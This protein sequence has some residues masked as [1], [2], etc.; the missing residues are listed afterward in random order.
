MEDDQ[1][2]EFDSPVDKKKNKYET[3]NDELYFIL[4]NE[5]KI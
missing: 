5:E 3:V 4:T 2:D 1:E